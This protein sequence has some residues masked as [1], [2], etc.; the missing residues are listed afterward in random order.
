MIACLFVAIRFES[1]SVSLAILLESML[2]VSE[3]FNF[4]DCDVSLA[5]DKVLIAF[6]LLTFKSLILLD[7][8]TVSV[9]ILSDTY[10]VFA[11]KPVKG[12]LTLLA[13]VQDRELNYEELERKFALEDVEGEENADDVDDD[14][15]S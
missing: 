11:N 3:I 6:V 14:G 9:P 13:P 10:C 4:K 15:A 2:E 12:K 7:K 8:E 1:E 5:A